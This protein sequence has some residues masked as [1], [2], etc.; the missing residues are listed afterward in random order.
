MDSLKS[1]ASR[2]GREGNVVKYLL[3][4]IAIC[5]AFIAVLVALF[6]GADWISKRVTERRSHGTTPQTTME[7]PET[8][9]GFGYKFNDRGQL[10]HIQT[11]KPFEFAV[12]NDHERNQRRY[13]ALGNLT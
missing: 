13:E 4:R 11:N 10:R 9:E 5:T 3:C 6:S 7:F 2:G 1:Q 12:Y 8:I